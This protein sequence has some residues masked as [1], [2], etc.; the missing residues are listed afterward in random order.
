MTDYTYTLLIPLIPLAVFLFTG[1]TGH[2]FKPLVSG[3][4][5]TTGLFVVFILSYMTAI[6]YFWTDHV[7]GMGYSSL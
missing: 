7:A 4:I 5:G 1:L 3:L 2:K 6:R